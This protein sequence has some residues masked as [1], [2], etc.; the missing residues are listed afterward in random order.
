MEK[1]TRQ[2]DWRSLN[3][4]LYD[5]GYDLKNVGDRL[6]LLAKKMSWGV[7]TEEWD[8][9]AKMLIT[10][11]KRIKQFQQDQDKGEC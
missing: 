11:S 8:Q 2:V 1:S 7:D 5:L 6:E 10:Y 9:I 3:D 4:D